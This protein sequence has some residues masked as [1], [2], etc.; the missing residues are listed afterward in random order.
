MIWHSWWCQGRYDTSRSGGEF[1][2][3]FTAA[4]N[5]AWQSQLIHIVH[6]VHPIYN[7]SAYVQCS[8]D[9][10]TACSACVTC[11]RESNELRSIVSALLLHRAIGCFSTCKRHLGNEI[12]SQTPHNATQALNTDKV[13]LT[14]ASWPEPRCV[15]QPRLELSAS[16]LSG[17]QIA[18]GLPVRSFQNLGDTR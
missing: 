14:A 15:R 9:R 5:T 7:L 6:I 17:R 13:Q 11:L 10:V 8:M 4:I 2:Q 18:A 1:A 16:A 12:S 3:G